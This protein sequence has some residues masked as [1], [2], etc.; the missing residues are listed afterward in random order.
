MFAI[1][2]VNTCFECFYNLVFFLE[3][4]FVLFS[5]AISYCYFETSETVQKEKKKN[6]LSLACLGCLSSLP[7]MMDFFSCKQ[8][9]SV[10]DVPCF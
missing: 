1:L 7:D 3:I 10:L 6:Y 4:C 8:L 9:D 5:E 2:N